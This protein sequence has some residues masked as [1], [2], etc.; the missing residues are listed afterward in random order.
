VDDYKTIGAQVTGAFYRKV[1][2]FCWKNRV[3][4]SD[5]VRQAIEEYI[6][7]HDTP[8]VPVAQPEPVAAE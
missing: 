4:Q 7:R 5:V 1:D 3:R 2:D 8:I 6:E